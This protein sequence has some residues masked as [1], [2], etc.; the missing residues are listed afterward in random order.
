M[1]L[2]T[3][4]HRTLVLDTETTGINIPGMQDT[5]KH[6]IIEIGAVEIINRKLTGKIFHSYIQPN[7]LIDPEAFSVHG[8]SSDFLADKPIFAEIADEFINFIYGG[9]LVIHNATFDIGFIDYEFHSLNRGIGNI[10]SFCRIIDSLVIAR[11]LFPGKRNSLDALCDRYLINKTTRHLHSALIDAKILAE[12]YLLM[13]GGQMSMTFS[14]EENHDN[15]VQKQ[16]TSAL[17]SCS[18]SSLKVIYAN[19]VEIVAHEKYLDLVERSNSSCLWRKLNGH[20]M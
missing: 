7:R 4:N 9:E 14:T 15:N 2:Q 6:R 13:T 18:S 20:N 3:S 11:K 16:I 17:K 8:I 12:V 5:D 1:V 10:E 19:D